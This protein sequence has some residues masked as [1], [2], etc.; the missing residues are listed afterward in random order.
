MKRYID[1]DAFLEKYE[2]LLEEN[3]KFLKKSRVP[4]KTEGY[5]HCMEETI[6]LLEQEP[7]VEM[8]EGENNA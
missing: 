3:W 2:R 7:V 5:I 6:Y 4:D 8:E 1:L